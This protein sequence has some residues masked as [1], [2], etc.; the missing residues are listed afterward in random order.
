MD[1]AYALAADSFA[2]IVIKIMVAWHVSLIFM[3]KFAFIAI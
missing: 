3:I 2:K 1:G